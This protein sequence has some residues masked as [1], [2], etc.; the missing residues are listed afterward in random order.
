MLNHVRIRHTSR[1]KI[2]WYPYLCELCNKRLIADVHHIKSSFH[3]KRKEAEDGSD[4]IGVCRECHERIHAHNNF[5]NRLDL[6][7][8]VQKILVE[9][10]ENDSSNNMSSM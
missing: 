9:V 7:D 2:V 1:K 8:K 10:Y 4:I 3:W 6:L 5:N